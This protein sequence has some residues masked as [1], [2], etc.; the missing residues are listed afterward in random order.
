MLVKEIVQD[1]LK[2]R[3]QTNL[4][5]CINSLT[6]NLCHEYLSL[7]LQLGGGDVLVVGIAGESKMGK[8]VMAKA[9]FDGISQAFDGGSF[10]RGVGQKSRKSNGLI[11]LQKQLVF[12]LL[13]ED[14]KITSVTRGM[15]AIKERLCQK[16]VLIVLDDVDELEQLFALVGSRYWFGLGSK[17]IITTRVLPMLQD[18]GVDQIFMAQGK[19]LPLDIQVIFNTL[20]IYIYICLL[21]YKRVDQLILLL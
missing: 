3:N 17:I 5:I 2:K 8:T 4:N 13:Q 11:Q 18:F 7:F 10:I 15:A 16:R 14:I 12:D 6:Y 9:I 19:P 20:Y 1:I 21:A